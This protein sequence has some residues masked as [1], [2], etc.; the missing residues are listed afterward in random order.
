MKR[1]TSGYEMKEANTASAIIGLLCALVV[2]P[3]IGWKTSLYTL[4]MTGQYEYFSTAALTAYMILFCIQFVVL[5][6]CGLLEI[7][8]GK[9]RSSRFRIASFH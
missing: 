6:V 9:G 8:T 5:L 7:C 1:L 4:L 2:G 3:I